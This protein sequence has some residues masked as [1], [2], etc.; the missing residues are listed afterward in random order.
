MRRSWYR[1]GKNI[2]DKFY[3]NTA[4]DGRVAPTAPHLEDCYQEQTKRFLKFDKKSTK[5]E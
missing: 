5:D 4:L 1:L 2:I 3:K